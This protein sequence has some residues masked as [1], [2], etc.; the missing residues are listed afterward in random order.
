MLPEPLF[1]NFSPINPSIVIVEYAPAIR[2]EIDL[3]M[4][5]NSVFSNS[6]AFFVVVVLFELCSY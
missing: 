3:L 6:Q 2:E 1:H 5:I 4:E